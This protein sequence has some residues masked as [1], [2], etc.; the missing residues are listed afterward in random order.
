MTLPGSMT[1]S[2]LDVV[3]QSH[4]F[5]LVD[6]N[7]ASTTRLRQQLVETAPQGLMKASPSRISDRRDC[8]TTARFK[9]GLLR[10]SMTL[11]DEY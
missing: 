11:R 4:C 10:Q 9:S 2:Q 7:C 1:G 3:D 5:A 8:V 6:E